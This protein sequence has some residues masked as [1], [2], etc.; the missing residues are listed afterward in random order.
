MYDLPKYHLKIEVK[1]FHLTRTILITTLLFFGLINAS[2]KTHYTIDDLSTEGMLTLSMDLP[3][4]EQEQKLIVRGEAWGLKPQ[5]NHPQ[6][7]GTL[8]KKNT[9][10]EWIVPIGCERVSWHVLP[11]NVAKGHVDASKQAT[12]FITSEYQNKKQILLSE[13]TSLLRLVNDEEGI[14]RAADGIAIYGAKAENT[15][16]WSV[17]AY[18]KAPEFYLVGDIR[19]QQVDLTN[20]KVRYFSDNVTLTDQYQLNGYHQQALKYLTKALSISP[21]DK[22]DNTLLVIWLGSNEKNGFIGG[23]AGGRSF[24]ANYLYSDKKD[25]KNINLNNAKTQL[26]IAHEQF[27]QLIDMVRENKST[28]PAWVEEGLAQYY[29]LKALKQM[30]SQPQIVSSIES[31][32]MPLNA[33]VTHTFIE[34]DK[35]FKAGDRSVYAEFYSQGATFWR[36]LDTILQKVANN[37]SGLDPFITELMTLPSESN[38]DLPAS[39]KNKMIAIGGEPV[40]IL[41]QQYIGQ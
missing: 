25:D 31:A 39:F 12:I 19:L 9:E 29:A 3:K 14:I 38:G 30:E 22:R 24:V 32:M 16:S 28:Q 15:S 4:S 8:L 5:I 34:L 18:Y 33:P 11:N 10:N 13:P 40:N 36:K 1:V 2:A 6:C 23:A 27:H 20:M 37:P 41:F 26:V 7:Q 21:Q 17:P 35:R